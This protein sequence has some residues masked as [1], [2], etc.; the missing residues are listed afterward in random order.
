MKYLFLETQEERI[1]WRPSTHINVANWDV[2]AGI[3]R[4]V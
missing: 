3:A 4:S 1:F 2:G